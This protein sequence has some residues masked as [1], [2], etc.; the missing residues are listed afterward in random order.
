MTWL[1]V[2]SE[3]TVDLAAEPGP[4]AFWDVLLITW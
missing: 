4:S 3:L 1:Q 2:L